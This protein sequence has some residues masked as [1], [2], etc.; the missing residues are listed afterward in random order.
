MSDVCTR[1]SDSGIDTSACWQLLFDADDAA[2][3]MDND[4]F[5]SYARTIR[6]DR[7]AKTSNIWAMLVEYVDELVIGRSMIRRMADHHEE[8]IGQWLD[9]AAW[10]QQDRPQTGDNAFRITL[11]PKVPF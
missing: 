7:R 3:R 8:V 10:D 5:A 1:R 6:R 4:D 9:D 2:Y 11:E